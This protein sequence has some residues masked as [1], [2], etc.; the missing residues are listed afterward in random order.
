MIRRR[1]LLYT[2]DDKMQE[3]KLVGSGVARKVFTSSSGSSEIRK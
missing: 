2:W 3:E 1:L